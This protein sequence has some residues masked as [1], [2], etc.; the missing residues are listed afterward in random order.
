MS[1][2]HRL[3]TW[4]EAEGNPLGTDLGNLG[5]VSSTLVTEGPGLQDSG[6]ADREL[7]GLRGAVI[8]QQV[9]LQVTAGRTWRQRL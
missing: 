3:P 1:H 2:V 8:L 5:A 6:L 9:L 4:P 7:D